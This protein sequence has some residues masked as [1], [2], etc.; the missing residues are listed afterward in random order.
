MLVLI[1]LGR[2]EIPFEF[3]DVWLRPVVEELK[4][5]WDVVPG[6]DVLESEGNRHFNMRAALLYTNHDFL[7]Y[8]K[9]ASISH[10]GYCTCPPCGEQL[11]GQYSPECWKFMYREAQHWLQTS[12][13]LHSYA[14]NHF[15]DGQDKRRRRPQAKT[16]AKQQ[17]AL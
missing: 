6:Y 10:Q 8:G 16:L 2:K 4:Q 13:Y 15:F 9:L 3:F 14:L 11:W 5:L 7:D 12:S 17:Q 1:I